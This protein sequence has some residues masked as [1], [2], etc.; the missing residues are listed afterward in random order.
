[1]SPISRIMLR[2]AVPL[3]LAGLASLH[4]F[5]S[6]EAMKGIRALVFSGG[7]LREPVRVLDSETATALYLQM[8]GGRRA[9][10]AD[11][12]PT[13]NG[14]RCVVVSAFIF[15]A[16][17]ESLRLDELPAG[18]GDYNFRLYLL[19]PGERPVMAVGQHIWRL[20]SAVTQDLAALGVP[21]ADT[22]RSIRD[23]GSG[24]GTR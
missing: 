1:M 15:N 3:G 16:R 18:Q 17:N 6:A 13:V 14:R 11:S 12:I 19:D 8:L 10:E 23:C 2:A 22:T 24:P 7:S 20:G 21:V 5:S 9:H 4:G